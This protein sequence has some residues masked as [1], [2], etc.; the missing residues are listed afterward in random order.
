LFYLQTFTARRG[1]IAPG[2]PRRVENLSRSLETIS[3]YSATVP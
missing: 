2:S 3:D 1:T